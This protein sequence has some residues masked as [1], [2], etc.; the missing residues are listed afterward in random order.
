LPALP[1]VLTTALAQRGTPYRD[2]GSS[3]S[4]GFDCSGFVQWVFAQH[5]A[6][7][8]REA[9]DQFEEGRRIDR[10]EVQPGD[11]VFF[12]TVARGASHV[13][14]ALG[15]GRFVHAPSTRGVVRVEGYSDGY[16]ASRWV[17]AR[18]I[19]ALELA[20]ADE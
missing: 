14:I 8:P 10:S 12:S 20:R 11:L 9:R 17:G 1:A 2:G 4:S 16:W 5:G 13:G 19:T 15:D 7:L 18:R 6:W 3:P